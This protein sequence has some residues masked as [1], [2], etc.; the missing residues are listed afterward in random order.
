M[1]RISGAILSAVV[2]LNSVGFVYGGGNGISVK[3]NGNEINTNVSPQI[4]DGR[5][6]IPVRDIF[7]AV[8]AQVEWDSETKT[9]SS[10]KGSKS[11]SMSIGSNVMYVDGE[12]VTMDTA[13]QIIDGR[14][15]APARYVAEAFGYN[16]E[17]D[18]ENKIVIITEADS[19]EEEENSSV[20]DVSSQR[21]TTTIT[22]EAATEATTEATTEKVTETTTETTT[23]SSTSSEIRRN[24]KKEIID[25][26]KKS[27]NLY[28]STGSADETS[29]F[30][31]DTINSTAD[32]WE[33]VANNSAEKEFAGKAEDFYKKLAKT[34]AAIDDAKDDDDYDEDYEDE[35]EE[36]VKNFGRAA[37]SDDIDAACDELD[38]L[39]NDIK[40][41]GRSSSSGTKS[42]SSGSTSS[43]V[44]SSKSSSGSTSSS[45]GS[46]SSS[47]GSSKS[48]GS[49]SSDSDSGTSSNKYTYSEAKSLYKYITNMASYVSD[50]SSTCSKAVKER[51]YWSVV[52]VDISNASQLGDMAYEIMDGKY[53]IGIN[54]GDFATVNELMA[55]ICSELDG[56]ENRDYDDLRECW[57]VLIDVQVKLVTMQKFAKE[58]VEAFS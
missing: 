52:K 54:G 10:S 6:M 31:S 25:F 5:T 15:V 48:S 56:I 39:Y 55:Y 29:L 53:E 28:V 27:Y 45:V 58:L 41:I 2:V 46:S 57:D 24:F 37:S 26:V 17:W 51:A 1:K 19:N 36:I 43:S 34:A 12:M 20:N 7:E 40:G 9:I 35:L 50:A 47:S 8:G 49:S 22:T 11:V 3:V 14:T 21:E 42:S 18:G 23:A 30:E 44:G 13:P 32:N 16:V 33:A 4:I 38:E